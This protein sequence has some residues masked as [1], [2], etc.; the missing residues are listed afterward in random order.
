MRTPLRYLIAA[1][2]A[3]WFLAAPDRA[4]AVATE[5]VHGTEG[6]VA[7][8]S[9]LASEVGASILRAGGNAVDAT[10]A[11]GFAL[12]VT[13]PSAG[14]L[15]GGGFLVIRFADG[16]TITN[17]HRERAPA[18]A[19]RD[20]YL[21]GDGN[22]VDG[23]S[24]ASH[25]AV[26]VPGTPAG[27]IDALTRYGTMDVKDVIAPAIRLAREGFRLDHDLAAEFTRRA[28]AF[29]VHAGSRKVF[30]KEDGEAWRP[31]ER[32][33]QPDL[34][35]TLMRIRRDGK[36][37]FYR[38][39]TA[40]LLV[41]EMQRGGGLITHEDLEN[42]T[43]VWRE[44]IEGTYRGHRIISMPP[45]SSGGVLLVQI[46]NMLEP[47][48][49]A[50]AGFG[51]A[52]LVHAMIEAE[53][54]AYA[55]R[56]EHLGDPDFYAVPVAELISKAYARERFTSFDPEQ[57]TPSDAIAPG[58]PTPESPDTT[59]VSVIDKQGNAVAY[60]TT[61]NL[62]YGS[63]IVAAGTGMLL[64]NEMDDF[65][66]KE[67]VPNFFGLVGRSANA[68]EPGKRMLSSMT[69]TIVELAD[70][71]IL[72]TGSPGGSTII[73]TTL[74][75]IMNVIDHGMD[76]SDAVSRPRFHHQWQPDRVIY[77]R[78]GLSPDTLRALALR[79]HSNLV[80]MPFGRGIGDANSVLLHESGMNGMADPRNEGAAVAAD[81]WAC[82]LRPGRFCGGR[83]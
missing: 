32:F 70:G 39:A 68:I 59:H 30:V 27:L 73:T 15:A 75:V 18:A 34:A 63:K 76:L 1:A 9:R 2:I 67:N 12:A 5:A 20:M 16:K 79:G 26:G 81:A 80:L 7:S 25:L 31:G 47:L 10:V 38:G 35:R 46:L 42:Y 53:R 44:P 69:P 50:G 36:D 66:A 19:K 17:D 77:E 72:A 71:R 82:E 37:G 8:R 33:R 57:A 13:Y 29:A 62:S 40:D 28:D 58:A 51:S 83:R 23:L 65:S 21:D 3:S 22:V 41:A 55:D 45:P 24:T 64:N 4:D 61:L 14:N 54:R 74:Q 49:V 52:D 48:D 56:A 60:T 11:T 43:S 78:F 6:M